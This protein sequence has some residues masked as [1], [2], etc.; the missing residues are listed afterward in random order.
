MLLR[1]W[2]NVD[3]KNIQ[4]GTLPQNGSGRFSCVDE[5]SLDYIRSL[6]VTH[7]WYTGVVRHATACDTNGCKSSNP[8]FVK[9]LA[10]S[11]YSITDW[12]DVN[13]Y[14]ADSPDERMAGFEAM[15][16]R[17][18]KAGLKVITDFIPNHVSR[19]YGAFSPGPIRDGLDANGHPVLGACDDPAQHWKA[20]N[21]FYWYP[22]EALKLPV[23]G[24]WEEYPAKASGNCFSPSP[25]IND[26]YDTVRLNYCDFHTPTW[27]KMLQ[28]VRFWAL[29][30]VDGVRCDMVEMVPKPFC[31]WL[32]AKIKEEFP[33]FVFIAEVYDREQYA[34]YL[35]EVGFDL[36]YDKSGM[37]DALHDIIVSGGSARILSWN[38]QFLG[39]LQ[40]GMLN[41]LE[42]H[43][44]QRIAS[45]FFA[46]SAN[47][48]YA[49]LYASALLNTAPFM[50]YFGQEAG[51]RGM[52]AEGFSG[53]N[54]RTTIF[55][56]WCPSSA[57]HIW[58]HIHHGEKLPENEALVLERYRSLGA[59][60]GRDAASKGRTF[61]LCYCQGEGFDP[62]RHFAFLRAWKDDALLVVCNF[63]G[64]DADIRINVPEEAGKYLGINVEG[65]SRTVS[66]PSWD[67][68]AI[69]FFCG[70]LQG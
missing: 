37:Y 33:D 51:E 38:W 4:S 39:D 6:G 17:T 41:F 50:L 25:G 36:L 20:E 2:G 23:P 47:R 48:S 8:A 1:Q 11:P 22:G 26:W 10:G 31:K 42:N 52:D 68:A 30:G 45:D 27:D 9:G 21:D 12:F 69:S 15:V 16:E 57:R 54:G 67:A 66:V 60:L 65:L 62:D 58:N 7:V 29:K 18:H 32:I 53:C 59:L 49:A 46:G 3:G 28:V 14:L 24:D 64:T 35:G 61:D 43:D 19:D 63:S 70:T 13:P 56:W 5:A 55:D 34:S 44:E 40:G